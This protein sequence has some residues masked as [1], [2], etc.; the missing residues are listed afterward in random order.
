MRL[1]HDKFRF[2]DIKQSKWYPEIKTQEHSNF[3]LIILCQAFFGNI[4]LILNP[5]SK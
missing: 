1:S 5:R 3:F 4:L 2:E